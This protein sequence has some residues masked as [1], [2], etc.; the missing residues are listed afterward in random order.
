LKNKI[1]IDGFLK[2][3]E[4]HCKAHKLQSFEIPRAITFIDESFSAKGLTTAT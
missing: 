1:V 2:E 3:I 4:K